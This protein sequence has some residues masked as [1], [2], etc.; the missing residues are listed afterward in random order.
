MIK[1]KKIKMK[2]EKNI[3]VYLQY[4]WKFPDSA[5]YEYLINNPPEKISYINKGQNAGVISRKSNF[6][7]SNKIKASIRKSIRLI[8]LP[9]LNVHK[10]KTKEKYNLIHCAHCLSLN[11]GPWVADFEGVWQCSISGRL[12]G[13]TKKSIR[14]ILLKDNCKKIMPWNETV[15][16][17]FLELFPEIKDKLEVVY[18]AVPIQHFKKKKNKKL[19]ILYVARYFWIKGGLVA[20]EAMKKLKE[21]YSL[22]IDFISDAPKEIRERYPGINCM[23]LMPPKEV[24]EYYKKADVFLY[25]SMV[26]TFGIALLEAMSFG[27]SIVTLNTKMTKTRHEII[28]NRKNGLILNLNFM[29]NFYKIGERESKIIDQLVKNVSLLI[30]NSTLRKKMSKNCIEEIKNGKFSMKERNKKLKKIYEEAI[31]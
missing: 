29:P 30:E 9:L 27:L 14:R 12:T 25:P 6:L 19:R 22:D 31:K 7:L 24:I 26:D 16:K 15:K 17:E 28:Q 13:Q 4:P 18:P 11:S 21:K 23:D 3:N 20:L 5:Y 2:S 1:T 10:T 8:N